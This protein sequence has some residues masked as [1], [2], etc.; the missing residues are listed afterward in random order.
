MPSILLQQV[1]PAEV[2]SLLPILRDADEGEQRIRDT[3]MDG[4]HLSYAAFDDGRLVG[5]ATMYWEQD[6]SEIRYIAVEP[7]VRGKGYGKAIIAALLEEARCRGTHALLV[8]TAT[9]S[10]DNLA[11]Y[12]KC[13]FRMDH[14]RRDY[15]AYIQPPMMENGIPLRDMVVLRYDWGMGKSTL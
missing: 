6:E 11:F 10:F 8:G 1:A 9:C 5:A 2:E 14:V 12:Q 7:E 13:G 3:L 4:V 15:F